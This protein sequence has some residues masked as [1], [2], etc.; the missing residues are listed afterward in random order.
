LHLE[1]LENRLAP[2]V[3]N[4]NSVADVL[5][6]PAGEVTL[7][8][9]I[10]QAN[11]TPG[12]NTINLT[13]AGTYAITIPP[14]APDDT[15]AT[16]NNATG[17]FDIIPNALSPANSTLTI[18]NTSGGTAVVTGNNLDRIFDINPNAA[19][20]PAG[21]TVALQGF[22]IT[23]GV[24]QPGNAATG[25][26]GGIRDQGNVSLTL[27]NMTVTGNQA[28]ADGGGIAMENAAGSTT[29]T[30]TVNSSTISNNNAD[31]AGGGI[32]TDGSGQVFINAGTQ[33]TG[34]RAVNQG[35]GVYLDA[36]ANQ[37]ATLTMTGTLVSGN[38][39]NGAANGSGGGISNAGNGAV[40]IA[41]STVENNVATRTGGGFSDA[42]NGLGTLTV[43]SSLFRNNSAAG[44]GGAIFVSGPSATITSTSIQGNTT[45]ASGGGLF[46]SGTT[47]TVMS[48]TFSG[49]RAAIGGGIELQTTGT[50]ANGSTITNS[51]LALNSALSNNA[52]TAGGGIDVP[53]TFT[54]SLTLLNDT[55]NDNRAD[56]G[57]GISWG[58]QQGSA[59]TVQNTIIAKNSAANGPNGPDA[60]NNFGMFT[61]A[62]GNLIGISGA[63]GGNFGFTAATTQTGTDASPL[64]P[65]LGPLTNNG[66]PTVGS[67]SARTALPTEALRPGSKALGKGVAAGAPATDERGFPRPDVT[68]EQPDVGAFENQVKENFTFFRK[69]DNS[70]W[71][72]A[73]GGTAVMLSPAGT[74]LAIT[75]VTDLAGFDVVFAITADRNLWQ[76]SGAN[77]GN[78]SK[79][80]S[81]GLFGS[82]SAA[83][84]QS[85]N[86]VVFGVLLDNSLWEYSSLYPPAT[87]DW[88]MLSPGGTIL[89]ASAVTDFSQ[90]SRAEV[91]YAI[92]VQG[93]NLQEYVQG[94][95]I[96]VSTG[97]F[98][99]ISAGFNATGNAVVY[100]V[101]TDRSLIEFNPHFAGNML[102]LSPAGTILSASAGTADQVFAITVQGNNLW[103]RST[104]GWTQLSAGSFQQIS[105]NQ[106]TSGAGEVFGVL[107]DGNLWEYNPAFPA[108]TGHFRQLTSTNDALFASAPQRF[109]Y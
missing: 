65:L 42:A 43:S 62:G 107:A 81:A 84:N 63:G 2:A 20:A 13:V 25:S 95:W 94:R 49:N 103:Q 70:L 32:E 96:P 89:S 60:F 14:A 90:G 38:S 100:A 104:A 73:Q 41:G 8:S 101:G 34:N 39:S 44:N 83:T 82:V 31:G 106:D 45:D 68:G 33:I 57:G 105:G 37:S 102:Q 58:G 50:G 30:L 9:A 19:N 35:A 12:S 22:S 66:G 17:D 99:Q 28:S 93:N 26:G 72:V 76:H 98:Q 48:S 92:M 109:G 47:L 6:P 80:L 67:P 75:S 3:F 86:A 24:A 56:F 78:G 74:I 69:K 61:D 85:G 87:G 108:G 71:Q 27:T 97:S 40:S 5:N 53:S 7:R 54:A 16:E 55:I 91:V 4:V 46:A 77:P 51:T 11:A 36:V 21:F 15:P 29:W 10:Q 88:K 23:G 59:I 52:S 64:D 1:P 79:E 18:V